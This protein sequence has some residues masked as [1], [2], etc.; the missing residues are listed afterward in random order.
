M[1]KNRENFLMLQ[2]YNLLKKRIVSL[3]LKPGQRH[4]L[5]LF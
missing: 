3:D 5:D 2:A 4:L 1:G